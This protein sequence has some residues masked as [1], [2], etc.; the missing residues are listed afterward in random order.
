MLDCHLYESEKST[1]VQKYT[2][3]ADCLNCG[4]DKLSQVNLDQLAVKWQ[5]SAVIIWR[6]YES[7]K[8]ALFIGGFVDYSAKWTQIKSES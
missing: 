8:R 2:I 6:I 5:C 7:Y 1:Y 4:Q 3:M